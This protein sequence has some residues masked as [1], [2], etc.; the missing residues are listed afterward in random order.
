MDT[1]MSEYVS[2]EMSCPNGVFDVEDSGARSPARRCLVCHLR[3]K[4]TPSRR[5][6]LNT[7]TAKVTTATRKRMTAFLFMFSMPSPRILL[8]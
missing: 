4:Y 1:I 6:R 8:G 2:H 5:L 3:F 7:A